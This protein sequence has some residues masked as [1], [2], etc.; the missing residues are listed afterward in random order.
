MAVEKTEAYVQRRSLEWF[1]LA[2]VF[3]WRSNTGALLDAQGRL[4]KFGKPG[5]GD[6]QFLLPPHGRLG[7]A[8][9]KSENGKQLKAQ[10]THQRKVEQAGGLYLVLHPHNFI[11]LLVLLR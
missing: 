4:V 8:E 1:A 6:I 2:G 5:M 3:A 7:E 9:C 10:R 11:D